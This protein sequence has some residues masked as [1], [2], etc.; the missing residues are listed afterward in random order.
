MTEKNR[1]IAI[2]SPP[3][4]PKR[5]SW[6]ASFS[7]G[8]RRDQ[9]FMSLAAQDSTHL[10][11]LP[12]IEKGVPC[13]I[14]GTDV[15]VVTRDWKGF[16]LEAVKNSTGPLDKSIVK[17]DNGWRIF[18]CLPCAHSWLFPYMEKAVGYTAERILNEILAM[19][20]KY[21]PGKVKTNIQQGESSEGSE[22]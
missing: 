22:S 20:D 7:N 17:D 1:E 19:T 9:E 15:D 10:D 18:F 11:M 12:V 16:S 6:W 21:V 3:I 13:N 2:S 4:Q 5:G 14:C 8:P